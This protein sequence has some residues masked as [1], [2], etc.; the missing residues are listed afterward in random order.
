MGSVT[1]PHSGDLIRGA[2]KNTG[3]SR[4]IRDDIED[5]PVLPIHLPPLP[6]QGLPPT[7]PLDHQVTA[8]KANNRGVIPSLQSRINE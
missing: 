2:G 5:R 8:L 3:P 4:V 6:D 7:H 1:R